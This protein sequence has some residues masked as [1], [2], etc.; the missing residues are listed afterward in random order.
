MPALEDEHDK[1]LLLRIARQRDRAAF[2]ELVT[3][4][5]LDAF[6]LASHITGNRMLAEE[7][8]QEALLRVWLSARTFRADGNARGWIL[9]IVSRECLRK[10]QDRRK[11]TQAMTREEERRRT[12][13]VPAAPAGEA[14]ELLAGLRACLGR[15]PE[16]HRQLVAL[17]FGGGLTQREISTEM[18]VPERTVSY[19]IDEALRWLREHLTE[20]GLAAALPLLNKDGLNQAIC[21]GPVPGGLAERI[22]D[23]A[24]GTV[25]HSARHSLRAAGGWSA[26]AKLMF[27][28]AIA[29]AAG[30]SWALYRSLAPQANE[31]A[32]KEKSYEQPADNPAGSMAEASRKAVRADFDEGLSA[33]LVIEGATARW[34]AKRGKAG[35][36]LYFGA[37][38]G[39]AQRYGYG[40]PCFIYP[41]ETLRP[42]V[43]IT[44]DIWLE[45]D[46][47]VQP[48]DA[49]WAEEGERIE[50]IGQI[51]DMSKI[52]FERKAQTPKA[53]EGTAQRPEVWARITWFVTAT[54]VATYQ[55]DTLTLFMGLKRPWS[56]R[57]HRLGLVMTAGK[58]G[59][60]IDNLEIQE[61]APADLP[62]FEAQIRKMEAAH[63]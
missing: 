27:A 1:D 57:A 53:Y 11:E 26:A 30:G 51:V 39:A 33:S 9:R 43:K 42:P 19:R 17:Y 23:A 41:A 54:D 62:D 28:I 55:Q 44:C 8:V 63:D 20:A 49:F 45:R 6:N 10:R 7:A 16:Q 2:E 24:R 4:F 21:S 32:A 35:G 60:V 34:V 13:P 5:H 14:Q 12:L 48:Y 58:K 18:N 50:R 46:A 59:C 3:R 52:R 36:G 56:E 29:C 15:L 25:A 37:D 47:F 31:R 40:A 22:L 38:E 61:I